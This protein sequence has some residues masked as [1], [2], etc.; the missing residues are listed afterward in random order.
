R[1]GQDG[2]AT[3]QEPNRLTTE[4]RSQR[5]QVGCQ[6]NH[7]VDREFAVTGFMSGPSG[8]AVLQVSA[9]EAA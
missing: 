1:H 5:G 4:S 3:K 9:A 7:V 2:R 8:P 6:R